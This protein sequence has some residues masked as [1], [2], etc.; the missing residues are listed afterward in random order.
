M[1]G[2]PADPYTFQAAFTTS[3]RVATCMDL[4]LSHVEEDALLVKELGDALEAEGYSTWNYTKDSQPVIDHQTQTSR[5][6][7]EAVAFVLLISPRSLDQPLHVGRE[8]L[9]AGELHRPFVPLLLDVPYAEFAE[10]QP[11]W[12]AALAGAVAISIPP[13][14]PAGIVPAIV[15]SL[16]QLDIQPS[17]PTAVLE[18]RAAPVED[19]AERAD[20]AL[21]Y[22]DTD[23]LIATELAD[24][25][26]SAGYSTW[27]YER[28]FLRGKTPS[29]LRAAPKPGQASGGAADPASRLTD[30]ILHEALGQAVAEIYIEPMEQ[31]VG[32]H[33][34][35]DGVLR[36]AMRIPRQLHA[37]LLA[38]LKQLGDDGDAGERGLEK[39]R[40]STAP[41]EYGERAV[42][43]LT[44]NIASRIAI[45]RAGA[46]VILF[47]GD[48]TGSA[49][50]PLEMEAPALAGKPAFLVQLGSSEPEAGLGLS[51][52]LFPEGTALLSMPDGVSPAFLATL[53][54]RFQ[55]V[56]LVPGGRR[57]RIQLILGDITE[58]KV[59]AIVNAANPTLLG[60]GGVDGAIHRKGGPQI[61]QEC[62]QLRRQRYPDGLPTG[63]A[64]AT[65]GGR[66]PAAWVIHTVGPIFA[67]SA[68]PAKALAECHANA[69]RIAD[70]LG[71]KSVAFPAIS[72][73][74]FGYPVEQAA[75][76][77]VGAVR[78]ATTNVELVRFVV[79][80]RAAYRAF[81]CELRTP[82]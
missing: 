20:V 8:V 48:A 65:T 47:R 81:E 32:I 36:E 61:L 68:D 34:R 14:G 66:L 67:N 70:E 69:L 77:A 82:T 12:D 13:E 27:Y 78:G 59:D 11:T 74:A 44:D 2:A 5:A 73:G 52:R 23:F 72:T 79:F 28:D 21:S 76:V 45:E 41:T 49:Q 56:G 3:R 50:L 17:I 64:V 62:K 19:D 63:A 60:G 10:R 71:A 43:R 38:R 33:F 25:L 31:G 26:E 15:R 42:V 37:G 40:I 80:D 24:A 75:P 53:V 30:T 46:V 16:R 29:G 6:I 9:R 35:V 18:V 4:F 51:G 57:L 39:L 22:F 58:Q 7:A 1:L 54:A 55:E